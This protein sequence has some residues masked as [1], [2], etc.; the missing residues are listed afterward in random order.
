MIPLSEAHFVVAMG[1]WL[2]YGKGRHP[3]SLNF[4]DCLSYAVAKIA[5][6]PLLCVG[7]DFPE[8]DIALA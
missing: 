8:T 6:L 1:A 4:G 3:A 5:D 2:I 7:D